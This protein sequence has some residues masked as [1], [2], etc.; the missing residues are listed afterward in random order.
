[1][2]VSAWVTNVRSGLV[3]MIEVAPE[4]LERERVGLRR[5]RERE[6]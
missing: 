1:M 2:A 3:S 5:A 6:R 4:V